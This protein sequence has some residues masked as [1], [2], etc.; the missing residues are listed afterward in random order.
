MYGIGNAGT[1]T[2]AGNLVF[3]GRVDG[4]FR[5][6]NAT[7]GEELWSKDL[8][9]GITAPPVT[10][11]IDGKQYI[12]V[13]VGFGGGVAGLGGDISAA[14]GWAYGVHDRRLVTFSLDGET[15][16]PQQSPAAE[17]QP[18]EM[19]QFEIDDEMADQGA[20]EYGVRCTVC[21]GFNAISAGM[22]PDLRG[23]PILASEEAFADIVRNGSR[24]VNGMPVYEHLSDEQ[25]LQIRHYVRREAATAL[26]AE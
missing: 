25:L 6:Y 4:T 24:Q 22:A 11:S 3:Q 8:G 26:A 2:T 16:L 12:A 10:Y 14:N 5:A 9:L 19:L 13:L 7:T 18:I 15:M 23:S 21:H 17:A 20:Y 1:M